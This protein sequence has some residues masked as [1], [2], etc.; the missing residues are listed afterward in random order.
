M[1]NVPWTNG[2]MLDTIMTW[3]WCARDSMLALQNKS[4]SICV[5]GG[6]TALYK[7]LDIAKH[8]CQLKF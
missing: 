8:D 6:R 5:D 3:L 4:L 2:S 7:D 1:S